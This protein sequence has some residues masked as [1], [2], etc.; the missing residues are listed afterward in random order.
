MKSD[1]RHS[2]NYFLD[3]LFN[4]ISLIEKVPTLGRSKWYIIHYW[5]LISLYEYKKF[6]H[7]TFKSFTEFFSCSYMCYRTSY[8]RIC[9]TISK[10]YMPLETFKFAM[11]LSLHIITLA[12]ADNRGFRA[13]WSQHLIYVFSRVSF[14]L[15]R[16][17]ER[18]SL[19]CSLTNH[20]REFRT[21]I[22]I[23]QDE[24]II[25]L[26]FDLYFQYV[27]RYLFSLRFPQDRN[28]CLKL[29]WTNETVNSITLCDKK[30]NVNEPIHLGV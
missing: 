15:P 13:K 21:F 5:I 24:L 7:L 30:V 12:H 6:W 26:A 23:I 18:K 28:I 2:C 11:K 1:I 20:E 22:L 4:G 9:W 10:L 14:M 8:N 19:L 27:C 3:V 16:R 17:I 29:W 25:F